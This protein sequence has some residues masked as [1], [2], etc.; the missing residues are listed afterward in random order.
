MPLVQ[1]AGDDDFAIGEAF[2]P[3]SAAARHLPASRHN[4]F[5]STAHGQAD[6]D[7]ALDAADKAF[8]ALAAP[9]MTD[10]SKDFRRNLLR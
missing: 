8:A 5:L 2:L 4:M 9:H 3:R 7:E 10:K 1:F 6:I